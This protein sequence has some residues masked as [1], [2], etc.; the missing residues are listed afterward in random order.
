MTFACV[1]QVGIAQAE[2]PA[3][4][5]QVFSAASPARGAH[6][7]SVQ[8]GRALD[9]EGRPVYASKSAF[10]GT[11]AV[12]TFSTT[13][14]VPA[15][16]VGD[17]A[18]L[19]VHSPLIRAA[20]TSSFGRRRD[21]FHGGTGM[22][23]GIDLAAPAGSPILATSDGVVESAGWNGGYGL[24][25]KLRHSDSVET[26]YGHMSGVAVTAGQSVRRGDILGYVGSTGRSTG[27]HLHYEQRV[28]GAAVRPRM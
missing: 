22:H 23:S 4:A 12:T 14:P 18:V 11:A 15:P 8:V 17:T 13:K 21:P 20:V 6:S 7:V 19:P 9:F 16:T 26:L 27:P 28:N 5:N 3:S 1:F 25:V 24:L 2:E 10:S